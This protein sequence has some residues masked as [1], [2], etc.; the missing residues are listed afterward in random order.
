MWKEHDDGQWRDVNAFIDWGG[1][2]ESGID[3]QH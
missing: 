2:E 3:G 1:G